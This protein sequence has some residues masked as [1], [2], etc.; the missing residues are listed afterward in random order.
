MRSENVL[1]RHYVRSISVMREC[2][3]VGNTFRDGSCGGMNAAEGVC[4][5]DTHD[6]WYLIASNRIDNRK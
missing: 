5:I 4:R 3:R 6:S 2:E 1:V